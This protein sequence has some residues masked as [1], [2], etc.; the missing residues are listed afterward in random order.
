M[1]HSVVVMLI[2]SL[3]SAVQIP[4]LQPVGKM[5]IFAFK[6]LYLIPHRKEEGK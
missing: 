5:L 4:L 6:F 3:W 2:L 1:Q